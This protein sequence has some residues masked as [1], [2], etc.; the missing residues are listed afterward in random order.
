MGVAFS[1]AHCDRIDQNALPSIA[2]ALNICLQLELRRQ[3]GT[4]Q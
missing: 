4:A 3:A 2:F 1:I